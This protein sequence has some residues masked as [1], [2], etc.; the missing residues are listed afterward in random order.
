MP[1][2]FKLC[3]RPSGTHRRGDSDNLTQHIFLWKNKHRVRGHDF[4]QGMASHT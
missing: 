1:V 4:A 3:L 2:N